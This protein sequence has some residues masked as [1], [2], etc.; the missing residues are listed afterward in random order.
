MGYSRV[1]EEY[2]DLVD[3]HMYPK[4]IHENDLLVDVGSGPGTSLFSFLDKF[5][6]K[7]SIAVDGALPM[8]QFIEQRIGPQMDVKTHLCNLLSDKIAAEDASA[9]LV[10]C[11]LVLP[12]LSNIS[13]VFDEVGRILTP[14]GYFLADTISF[15]PN[16]NIQN[17][18][19]YELIDD[20]LDMY[21]YSKDYLLDLQK[22]HDLEL[23]AATS[24]P[25]RKTIIP[26]VKCTYSTE[27]FKK[28]KRE[29][30][31]LK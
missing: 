7:R 6:F 20:E 3:E 10:T 2:V 15:E 13:N 18:M 27:L 30:T 11:V 22:K 28:N 4:E 31:S 17:T 21:Y 8:L 23:V 1:H 12:Y 5:N 16:A 25:W 29:V 9:R 14:G 26:T 19:L 24:I